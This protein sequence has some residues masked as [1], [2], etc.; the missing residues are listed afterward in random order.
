MFEQILSFFSW[1]F[2]VIYTWHNNQKYNVQY[3]L[4]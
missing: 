1:L 4:N 3:N 2:L